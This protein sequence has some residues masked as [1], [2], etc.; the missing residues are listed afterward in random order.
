[1]GIWGPLQGRLRLRHLAAN[2]NCAP[3][4]KL[5][6]ASSAAGRTETA[7]WCRVG[8][9]A[10]PGERISPRRNSRPRAQKTITQTVI[11]NQPCF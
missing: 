7:G 10:R 3:F 2:L 5:S 1:M 4:R 11:T 6:A 8:S 9:T